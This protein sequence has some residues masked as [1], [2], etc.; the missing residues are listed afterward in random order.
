LP[1]QTARNY[2][3]GDPRI[4]C[5]FED[6]DTDN[7][8]NRILRTAT[9]VVAG[10]TQLPWQLRQR[11]LRLLRPFDGVGELQ[12]EDL[13]VAVERRNDWYADALTLARNIIIGQGRSLHAGPN[14]TW[15]FLFRTP[16]LI[17]EGVRQILQR[18]LPDWDVNKQSQIMRPSSLRLNPDL[19]VNNGFAIADIKYK[20]F[21][22]NW[23]RDDLYQAV[24]F[25]AGF[26]TLKAAVIGFSKIGNLTPP[27]VQVGDF[28]VSPLM[29]KAHPDLE[30]ENAAT[31]LIEQ[32]TSWLSGHS[33]GAD[34]NTTRL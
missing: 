14:S 28:A 30:P 24:A 2:Y 20:L 23:D 7:A 4:E 16:D 27:E 1:L 17:E 26:R 10:S 31:D 29:W 11:A 18:T 32:M 12:P 15:T 5:R 22:A 19:V 3:Q 8:L 13:N 9:T 6:F 34:A 25:A 33:V 21:G